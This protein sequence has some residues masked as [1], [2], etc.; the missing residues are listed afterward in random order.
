MLRA[1]KGGSTQVLETLNAFA[2]WENPILPQSWSPCSFGKRPRR[3]VGGWGFRSAL[4]APKLRW[5]R[6]SK[7]PGR[8]GA[9]TAK[10]RSSRTRQ[11]YLPARSPLWA[12][13]YIRVQHDGQ[14][15]VW[16]SGFRR[17][18]PNGQVPDWLA[19]IFLGETSFRAL[20]TLRPIARETGIT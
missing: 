1:D 6:S 11:W 9:R 7:R 10:V 14:I 12:N 15:E 5:A 16:G 13:T 17:W 8:L 20:L 19:K 4:G 3:M 18:P 2:V